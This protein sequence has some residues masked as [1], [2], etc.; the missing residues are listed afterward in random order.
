MTL[1]VSSTVPMAPGGA[2]A[3]SLAER[4]DLCFEHGHC[5]GIH[6]SLFAGTSV[7]DAHAHL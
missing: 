2:D 4:W 7:C 6:R 5:A 1:P 3:G